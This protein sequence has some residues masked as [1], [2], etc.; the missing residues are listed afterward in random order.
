MPGV[1]KVLKLAH[2]GVEARPTELLHPDHFF[3]GRFGGLE[4]DV[5]IKLG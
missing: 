3:S 2:I 5:L 4:R 1:S